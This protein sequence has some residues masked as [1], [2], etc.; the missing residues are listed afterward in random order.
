VHKQCRTNIQSWRNAIGSTALLAI[1]QL[2]KNEDAESQ[3]DRQELIKALLGDDTDIDDHTID[4]TD[5]NRPFLWE[6]YDEET[7]EQQVSKIAFWLL[8]SF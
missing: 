7:D 3:D 2:L 6:T 5:P 1:P 4:A 8:T